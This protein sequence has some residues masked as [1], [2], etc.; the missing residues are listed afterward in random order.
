MGTL[1]AYPGYIGDL[2]IEGKATFSDV[3]L[4]A[5]DTALQLSFVL[6]G[7]ETI[8]ANLTTDVA[9]AC[10]IHIHAG[11]SCDDATKWVVIFL[12]WTNF[13]PIR[14]PLWFTNREWWIP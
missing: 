11:T 7:V 2:H 3:P 14:G 13:K 8:C 1:A 9:N 10:G 4:A 5:S 12:Q 6:K